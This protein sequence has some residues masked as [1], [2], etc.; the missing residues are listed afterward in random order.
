[1]AENRLTRREIQCILLAGQGLTNK[2]IAQRL[3]P[4]G[5]GMSYR[6][7]GNHLSSA[8]QKLGTT[9]RDAAAALV[10]QNYTD[11]PI[12]MG[13]PPAPAGDARITGSPGRDAG[14]AEPISMGP[15][16]LYRRLG[17]WRTPPRWGGSRAGLIVIWACVGLLLISVV[18]G[19]VT[20]FGS[21]Q[22]AGEQTHR[23]TTAIED[24]SMN[25]QTTADD[26][27]TVI[28]NELHN[29]EHSLDGTLASSGQLLTTLATGRIAAGLGAG[30]GQEGAAALAEAINEMMV[31]RGRV[32][33][34]HAA[35]QKAAMRQGL[36]W[37]MTGT[38]E[39]KPDDGRVVR[40]T[41]ASADT[42]IQA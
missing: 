32:A 2:E 30:V 37:T 35:L 19:L 6:T 31:A 28:A 12:P 38:G 14:D 16:G 18:L 26:F 33:F 13:N 27:A 20:V 22:R 17:T 21:V 24:L 5:Q 36:Q 15:Y 23:S 4:S 7:V 8:Y 25:T 1:M 3:R 39:S 9:D 11:R 34:A 29:V 41:R 10:A 40:P 42:A